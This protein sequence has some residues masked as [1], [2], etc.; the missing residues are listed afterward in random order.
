MELFAAGHI[1]RNLWADALFSQVLSPLKPSAWKPSVSHG[2]VLP[3]T[4]LFAC[5]SF[6][7]VDRP[8]LLTVPCSEL[9]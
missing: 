6:C 3:A 1:P 7:L 5:F 2:E 9:C 8:L 4:V